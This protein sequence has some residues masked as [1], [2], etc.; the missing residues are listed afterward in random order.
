MRAATKTNPTHIDI[1]EQGNVA[2]ED[3]GHLAT[4]GVEPT[5]R[6]TPKCRVVCPPAD[7]AKL[8]KAVAD[9][10]GEPSKGIALTNYNWNAK[11]QRPNDKP[12]DASLIKVGSCRPGRLN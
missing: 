7:L 1:G 12:N 6:T 9:M 4:T 3:R 2:A 11:T 8:R 5:Y 10:L